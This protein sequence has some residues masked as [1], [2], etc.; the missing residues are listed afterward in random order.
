[1]TLRSVDPVSLTLN[2]PVA[3]ITPSIDGVPT[4]KW[5]AKGRLNANSNRQQPHQGCQHLPTLSSGSVVMME[6]PDGQISAVQ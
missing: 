6:V 2:A 5:N 3:G 4:N 1:M